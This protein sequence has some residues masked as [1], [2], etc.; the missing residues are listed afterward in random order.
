[1]KR[2]GLFLL[3][4]A[5]L[6]MMSFIARAEAGL[7]FSISDIVITPGENVSVYYDLPKDGVMTIALMNEQNEI[8][9]VLMN[10]HQEKER[11]NTVWK[12]KQG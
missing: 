2:K 4:I 7:A 12:R 6:L 9:L 3:L 5:L 1:M 11:G 8:V 10:A